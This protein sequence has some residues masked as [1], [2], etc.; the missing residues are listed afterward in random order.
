MTNDGEEARHESNKVN[1][2]WNARATGER[3]VGVFILS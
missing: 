2:A 1:E 3:V